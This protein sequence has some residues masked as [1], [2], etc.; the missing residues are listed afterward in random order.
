MPGS[1]LVLLATSKCIQLPA[2]MI[3]QRSAG[4]ITCQEKISI[5]IFPIPYLFLIHLLI[6]PASQLRILS[7]LLAPLQIILPHLINLFHFQVAHTSLS[8]S[9]L[10]ITEHFPEKPYQKKFSKLDLLYFFHTPTFF[11]H[12]FVTK[13]DL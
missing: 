4:F 6:S 8:S 1:I 7:Q 5:S 13:L 3:C 12:I 10:N 9:L 2:S 11:M